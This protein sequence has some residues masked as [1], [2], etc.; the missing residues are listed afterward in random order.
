MSWMQLVCA[1]LCPPEYHNPHTAARLCMRFCT[2][3]TR[4]PPPACGDWSSW[5]KKS[6][7]AQEN[8]SSDR[9]NGSP[10]PANDSPTRSNLFM[11]PGRSHQELRARIAF[12]QGTEV[13][14]DEL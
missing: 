6:L 14:R 5:C 8:S 2:P 7:S 4:P 12:T 3:S 10:R 9:P 1:C 13:A 11:L